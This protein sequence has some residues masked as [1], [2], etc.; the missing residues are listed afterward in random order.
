MVHNPQ[1]TKMRK[2]KAICLFAPHDSDRQYSQK[3]KSH[4]YYFEK[5]Y[6]QEIVSWEV[7]KKNAI[8]LGILL[9]KN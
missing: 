9:E 5:R 4:F 7:R 8:D 6:L 2:L 1:S 3:I